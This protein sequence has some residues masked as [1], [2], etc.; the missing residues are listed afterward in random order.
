MKELKR[1]FIA[2]ASFVFEPVHMGRGRDFPA[3]SVDKL[4]PPTRWMICRGHEYFRQED[5]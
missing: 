4:R 2:R 1:S 3:D 5:A